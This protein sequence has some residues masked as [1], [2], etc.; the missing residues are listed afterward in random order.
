MLI[1]SNDDVEKILNMQDFLRIC[2]CLNFEP[3]AAQGGCIQTIK[4]VCQT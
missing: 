2:Q 3:H 1:L 4:C